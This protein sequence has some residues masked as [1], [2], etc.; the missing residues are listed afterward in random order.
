MDL[1]CIAELRLLR[2][3]FLRYAIR[4]VSIS[5]R[6]DHIIGIRRDRLHRCRIHIHRHKGKFT[7]RGCRRQIPCV[8][9]QIRAGRAHGPAG[10]LF[11]RNRPQIRTV[12]D[13]LMLLRNIG[14]GQILDLLILAQH[15]RLSGLRDLHRQLFALVILG[16]RR[17][18]VS[19]GIGCHIFRSQ[20]PAHVVL[21]GLDLLSRRF[22]LKNRLLGKL[23]LPAVG[24]TVD[25]LR[26]SLQDIAVLVEKLGH[27]LRP[28]VVRCQRGA[29]VKIHVRI[30]RR[31]AERNRH[32]VVR[33]GR[34]VLLTLPPLRGIVTRGQDHAQHKEHCKA[35]HAVRFFTLSLIHFANPHVFPQK[36]TPIA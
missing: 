1:H 19:R 16:H 35:P 22:L 14:S 36:P 15:I 12:A 2:F 21:G 27:A 3:P 29:M 26:A 7:L 11:V 28:L 34:S 10:L 33:A 32:I 6:H 8:R 23:P 25:R 17:L 13:K 24:H 30:R 5:V 4:M 20:H 18:P 31:C 9:A